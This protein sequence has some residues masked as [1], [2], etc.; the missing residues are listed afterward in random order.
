MAFIQFTD[1]R[2]KFLPPEKAATIWLVFNGEIEGTK[3]QRTFVKHIH[4]MFLNRANAPKSYREK[5]PEP[6]SDWKHEPVP[7][8]YTPRKFKTKQRRKS[9]PKEV[10][11]IRLPYKD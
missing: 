4:R 10:P 5:Y 6:P 2:V 11:Q 3:E 9:K 8:T 7:V 1:N